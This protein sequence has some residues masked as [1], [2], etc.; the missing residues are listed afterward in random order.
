VKKSLVS[1]LKT[2]FALTACAAFSSVLIACGLFGSDGRSFEDP[3]IL[4]EQLP[5]D[6]SAIDYDSLVANDA[7]RDSDWLP[8]SDFGLYYPPTADRAY[9][10]TNPQPT[11]YAPLG[12]PVVAI[13]TGVVTSV[14]K[15]YSNDTSVMIRAGSGSDAPIWEME[16]VVNV[17]VRVGDAVV[18]GETIADVS[19][20][21][22]KWGRNSNPADPLCASG[23]GLVEIGLLYGGNPP[24]HRCPFEDSL[25][26]PARRTLIFNQ[27]DSARARIRAATGD[28]T[29]FN[30][31]SWSTPQCISLTRVPG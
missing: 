23:L 13:V 11:F 6:L 29:L 26:A 30:K 15:L 24:E 2:G 21:E 16:H 31:A 7:G 8:I 9:G 28:T 4:L 12:T 10:K 20:Y 22:C 17:R 14:T 5:I 25:V 19:D 27:L 18:A 3:S 1:V